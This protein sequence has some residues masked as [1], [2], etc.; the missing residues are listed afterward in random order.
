MLVALTS[1]NVSYVLTNSTCFL[2]YTVV[3]FSKVG[4]KTS[5]VEHFL[6]CFDIAYCGVHGYSPPPFP[7]LGQSEDCL[8]KKS[9]VSQDHVTCFGR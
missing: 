1:F 5:L 3:Y 6:A 8:A 7:F 2:F 4:F 9:E